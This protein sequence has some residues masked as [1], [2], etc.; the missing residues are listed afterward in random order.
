MRRD[1]PRENS[2]KISQNSRITHLNFQASPSPSSNGSQNGGYSSAVTDITRDPQNCAV[3]N[4]PHA[5]GVLLH[6]SSIAKRKSLQRIAW[7]VAEG[8]E[9]LDADGIDDNVVQV[10]VYF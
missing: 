8:E 9:L 6:Q 5:E 1:S 3:I 7:R 2:A 10:G 4:F